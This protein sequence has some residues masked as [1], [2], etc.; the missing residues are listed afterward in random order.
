MCFKGIYRVSGYIGRTVARRKRCESCAA[1][2]YAKS[3]VTSDNMPAVASDLSDSLPQFFDMD[4]RGG[5]V[6]PTEQ[7][8]LLVCTGYLYFGV[9]EKSD[10][11][12][13]CVRQRDAFVKASTAK[14]RVSNLDMECDMGHNITMNVLFHLFNCCCKNYLKRNNDDLYCSIVDVSKAKTKCKVKKLQSK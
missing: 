11:F 1:V 6:H 5:L 13:A 14:C 4:N 7:L 12:K 10:M 3:G 2:L 8:F 9:L